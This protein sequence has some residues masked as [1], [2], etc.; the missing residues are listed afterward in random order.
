M[1]IHLKFAS[2]VNE[3]K[4][5]I[6]VCNREDYEILVN[7]VNI[8]RLKNNPVELDKEAIDSIY[9]QILER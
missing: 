4:I 8:E 2:I 5:E 6:P 7:S 1:A 3:L 9:H